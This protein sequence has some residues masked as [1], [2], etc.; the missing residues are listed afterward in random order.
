MPILLILVGRLGN[1]SCPTYGQKYGRGIT[2]EW[3]ARRGLDKIAPC[4]LGA[5]KP[6]PCRVV[7][8]D[9]PPL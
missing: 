7:V 3:L 1:A 9:A 5:T 6:E 8:D 2:L 4:K